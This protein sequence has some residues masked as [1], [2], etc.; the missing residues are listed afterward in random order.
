MKSTSHRNCINCQTELRGT[1]CHKCGEKV[2][3]SEDF[4]IIKL[5]EQSVDVFTHLDSK[6]Y[7]TVKTLFLKPGQ[8]STDYVQGLRK[9][10][11]K[12]FQL[13]IIVN[14]LFFLLLSDFDVFRKPASWWFQD[15]SDTGYNIKLM[16][17]EKA[18][19]LALTIEEMA[20]L[21][22]IKSITIAKGFVIV[23]IPLLGIVQAILFFRRKMQLGKHFI[24]STHYFTF[25]LLIMIVWSTLVELIFSN[26]SGRIFVIPIE[27]FMFL[28]L[29][30]GIK[31]FYQ[32]SWLY[33]IIS[34]LAVLIIFNVALESYRFWVSFYSLNSLSV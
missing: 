23:F 6:L 11:M 2:V 29:L 31:K 15:T 3:H 26:P 5:L 10:Y 16:A 22:E 27:T 19:E 12:P 24:F 21:Y 28:Y 7:K 32:S 1:F 30:L 25:V 20:P 13:F 34:S 14:V 17:E 18:A 33:T 9:P 4:S 8:I